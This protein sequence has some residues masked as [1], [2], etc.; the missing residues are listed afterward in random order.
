MHCGF[1]PGSFDP[2][3]LGHSDII[4][5]GLKIFDRLVVGIG[6]HP[7]KA[8]MFADD[9]RIAMLEEEFLR[10]G[11]GGR[12][13][14][15]LFRG[16]TVEAAREHGARC[17]LRGLRD[18]G[19]LNYEMQLSGMNA[20]LAPDIETIFVAASPGTVHITATLVRQIANFGGDVSSF[21]SP[22]VLLRMRDKFKLL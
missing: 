19:D 20:Q 18:A 10:L 22:P 16:L 17:I 7:A 12:A 1:Y 3:T 4:R 2:P 13:K 21:V 5:R 8:P 9:E 6:V 14:A 11:A 15:V